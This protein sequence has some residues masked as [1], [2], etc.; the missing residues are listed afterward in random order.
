MKYRIMAILVVSLSI[1]TVITVPA[2]ADNIPDSFQFKT[3][4]DQYPDLEEK[5]LSGTS[6]VTN[7]GPA[8]ITS[9]EADCL[10]SQWN[11]PF[12]PDVEGCLR[13]F[14]P[15]GGA[16]CEA[17]KEYGDEKSRQVYKVASDIAEQGL[18]GWQKA[19]QQISEGEVA[20]A[21][22]GWVADRIIENLGQGVQEATGSALGTLGTMW[23]SVPLIS[24]TTD[25]TPSKVSNQLTGITGILAVFGVLVGA[26]RLIMI[27][28]KGEAA[29]LGRNLLLLVAFTALA[30]P[31]LIN[32]ALGSDVL[33]ENIINANLSGST[34]VE[35]SF[36]GM[37][38]G[39]FGG[40]IGGVINWIVVI[41]LG[42][43][44]FIL[45]LVQIV[46]MI[47]RSAL[48]LVIIALVPVVSAT[49]TT[50]TGKEWAKRLWAWC[51]GLI[52]YKPIAAV[53]Y[54]IAINTGGL[55]NSSGGTEF[56]PIMQAICLFAIAIFAMPALIRF[57]SP[58]TA[59]GSG[60][61]GGGMVAGAVGAAATGAMIVNTMHNS[62]GGS[63]G[64]AGQAPSG[65]HSAGVGSGSSGPA[66]SSGT[67]GAP[68]PSGAG[69]SSGGGGAAAAGGGSGAAAGAAAGPVVAAGVAAVSAGVGAA[70]AGA[71]AAASS[72]GSE[73][74]SGAS[75]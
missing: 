28:T 72:V 20:E 47:A 12:A 70:R 73:E 34:G 2:Y 7:G 59:M 61:S 37:L 13:D 65:A 45:S 68:G 43:I 6:S 51:L 4:F 27:A 36:R 56:I 11:D 25:P 35:A 39:M 49:V 21:V 55:T 67:S 58:V 50:Q 75:F 71:G 33:A 42:I 40:A 46:M 16:V 44:V 62:G 53:I 26:G 52:C 64:T 3:C 14:A 5:V 74:P 48:L 10:V 9:A 8:D 23:M 29:N 24:S 31:V 15:L 54:A 66:G 60:G 69:A 30:V 57:F 19:V 63:G 1:L 32:L 22:V 38:K 17:Y 18:T 41:I